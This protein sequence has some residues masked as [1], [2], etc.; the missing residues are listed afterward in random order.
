LSVRLNSPGWATYL[1][2]SD[3][4]KQTPERSFA[5]QRQRI[6]EQLLSPSNL[7]FKREYCDLLSGTTANRADYQQLLADAEAGRF[8]N[9]GLYRADRFGRDAVEGLQAASRLISYGIRLRVANMPSLHPEEPDGFFMFLLQM[10]F[11]Q[12]EVDVLRQRT[13]DGM[14]AKARGGGWPHKAPEGYINKERLV[15]SNKYDRWVEKD[16]E[17][18][19]IIREAWD[20]LLTNRYTLAQI[21][22]ELT[23]RGYT[24]STGRPWAWD[25]K[26]NGRRR[27]AEGRLHKIFH[28]PF[29]AGWMVS[30]RFGIKFGEVRGTWEPTV[31]TEEYRRGVD[32]LRKHDVQKSR[33]KRHLYLLRGLLWINVEGKDYKMYG[34]TPRGRTHTYPYYITHAKPMGQKVHI[35]CGNI[36]ERIP[37]WLRGLVID[38]DRVEGIRSVYMEQVKSIKHE[39][40]DAKLAEMK[41][42]RTLLTEEEARLARLYITGKL[43]EENYDQLRKEWQDKVRKNELDISDLEREVALHMDDLGIALALMTKIEE[44]Y[45][46][47]KIKEKTLLLQ[48]LTKKIVVNTEGE[49]IDYNLNSPFAY[50]RNIVDQGLDRKY[51][52][53]GSEQLP[54]GACRKLKGCLRQNGRRPILLFY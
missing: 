26:R 18:N 17:N 52:G 36:D 31:T 24:R 9:L 33:V 6:N 51:Y 46:R 14:E 41:R 29:Y 25:D 4:D 35:P 8:S 48:I 39:D 54:P 45:Q 20:L 5:M 44:Y 37:G 2:V 38:P 10:G 28:S 13:A 7:P 49:I 3:E 12:R 30:E 19:H 34:S 53:S 40:H 16:P 43:E 22:E 1:R 32:I 47:L 42:R 11:A 23:L 50:L 15:K 27:V 21:C